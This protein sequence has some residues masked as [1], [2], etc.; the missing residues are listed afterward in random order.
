[1]KIFCM[2]EFGIGLENEKLLR[3]DSKESVKVFL[4]IRWLKAIICR[5]ITW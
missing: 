5:I 4:L 3:G 1:M 2:D